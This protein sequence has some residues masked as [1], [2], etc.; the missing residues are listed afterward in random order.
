MLLFIVLLRPGADHLTSPFLLPPTPADVSTVLLSYLVMLL[1]IGAALGRFPCGATW[2]D[3]LVHSRHVRHFMR[4]GGGGGCGWLLRRLP[5]RGR[6][7]LHSCCRWSCCTIPIPPYDSHGS[8]SRLPHPPCRAALGLGGV[9]IVAAAVAGALGLCGWAGLPATLIIMEVIP[10]LALAGG[11][12]SV[13]ALNPVCFGALGRGGHSHR[14]VMEVILRPGTG[15]WAGGVGLGQVGHYSPSSMVAATAAP[16]TLRLPATLPLS[17]LF[18]NSVGVDNMM[19][20]A[21]ALEQQPA[22]HPLEHRV[23]LAL[24]AVGPSITLAGGCLRVRASSRLV[25]L[26][27]NLTPTTQTLQSTPTTHPN[28]PPQPAPLAASCEAVAFAL[29]AMTS[30]PAL[31]AF[32]ACAAL[33]VALDFALQVTAFVALL[34][35]DGKRLAQGRYD[36][37]PWLR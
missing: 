14:P 26:S 9:L 1:Y 37:L 29:G 16:P 22:A 6:E 3:L 31:R 11:F 10:F 25:F 17:S 34:A 27:T 20:L 13:S 4:R 12:A 32:S 15:R 28:P 19:I 8:S 36:C 21:A 33:A 5:A 2:R 35:L 24:A 23:G 7:D 30:M 18:Q